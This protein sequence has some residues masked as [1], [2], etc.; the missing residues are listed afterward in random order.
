M[1]R[2]NDIV[3]YIQC[4]YIDKDDFHAEPSYAT[5]FEFHVYFDNEEGSYH[6]VLPLPTTRHQIAVLLSDLAQ[7]IVKDVGK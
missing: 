7:R 4:E 2:S 5:A 3:E 6:A 1:K